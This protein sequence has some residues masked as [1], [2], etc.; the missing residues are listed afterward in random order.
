MMP[1]QIDKVTIRCG[2]SRSTSATWG[3]MPHPEEE[4]EK[5]EGHDVQSG[6]GHCARAKLAIPG[7]LCS[8]SAQRQDLGK[9]SI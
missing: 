6:S 5:Q 4:A 2:L 9:G 1:F 3:R 7:R 8:V